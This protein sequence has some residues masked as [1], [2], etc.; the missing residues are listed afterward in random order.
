MQNK[1]LFSKWLNNE[2]D[3]R[4][5]SYFKKTEDYKRYK[6]IVEGASRLRKPEF[7]EQEGLL[8]LRKRLAAK[9]DNKNNNNEPGKILRLRPFLKIAAVLIVIFSSGIFF[10][11]N[12]QKTFETG[13]SQ[14]LVLELPDH[15][16]VRIKPDSE[17]AYAPSDWEE[18]REV[19]LEG[20]AYFE[21]YKGERFTVDTDQGEVIVLGTKFHVKD[22]EN[23]FEV[24]C[25]E[26][27]VRVVVE[28]ESFILKA[29]TSLQVIDGKLIRSEHFDPSSLAWTLQESHF[30]AVPLKH[31]LAELE[32]QF[33]LRIETKKVDLDLLF[34]G[35]FSHTDK[36]IA[37]KSIAIP[38]GLEYQIAADKKVLL[39][40]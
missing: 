34:T 20:E 29:G 5:L 7:D 37:L 8:D 27:S 28:K 17:I 14:S 31:V 33:D 23:F 4:E 39:Y 36:E 25:Y 12:R 22:R 10:L 32:R 15:S 21:V 1:E 38:L 40:E 19:Q 24:F 9:N 18:E 6:D 26:G 3:S 35:S 30:R 11:L 2:L 13:N 16:L